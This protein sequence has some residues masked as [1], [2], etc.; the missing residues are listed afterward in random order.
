MKTLFPIIKQKP[1]ASVQPAATTFSPKG[2]STGG[3]DIQVSLLDALRE[4]RPGRPYNTLHASEVM[5][6]MQDFC[7]RERAYMVAAELDPPGETLGAAQAFTF[8]LGWQ[9]QENVTNAARL[10]GIA[11][12]QWKCRCGFEY[13]GF[14]VDKCPKCTHTQMAYIEDR[15]QSAISG[16]SGSVDLLVLTGKW[17]TGG[18]LSIVEIKSMMKEQ[19]KEL[20]LPLASH[21][22]RTS[23]YLRLVEESTHPFRDL[24]DT[25]HAK[26][27]YACKGGYVSNPELKEHGHHFTPFKEYEIKR[28][29]SLT[30]AHL[31]RGE[32]F[33]LWLSG[34]TMELPQ[35]ICETSTCPRAKSCPA[36]LKCFS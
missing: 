9:I 24:V 25:S 30:D 14:G 20:A 5:S 1:Q 2:L 11:W 31:A 35:R 27:L 33:T 6:E 36:V 15:F 22:V 23:A 18:C 17:G 3:L 28:D 32:A 29:D 16:V 26:I 8:A 13:R 4:E 19:F 21:R 7:P 10:A 12:G 34:K